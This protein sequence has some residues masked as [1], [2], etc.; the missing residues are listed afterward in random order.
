M[1]IPYIFAGEIEIDVELALYKLK[2]II[3]IETLLLEGGSILDG[4]FV[5]G[6]V[7]DEISLVVAPVIADTEDKPLFMKSKMSEFTLAEVKQY[8][9]AVWLNYKRK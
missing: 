1:E 9:N 8:D 2:N 4:A 7:I 6:D 3:G 5:E